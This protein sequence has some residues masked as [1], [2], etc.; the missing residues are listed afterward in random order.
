[1]RC[2]CTSVTK[3]RSAQSPGFNGNAKAISDRAWKTKPRR[4]AVVLYMQM[5]DDDSVPYFDRLLSGR[6]HIAANGIRHAGIGCDSK[7]KPAGVFRTTVRVNPDSVVNIDRAGQHGP[8]V[9]RKVYLFDGG[10]FHSTD[11]VYA[12][13][14][15]CGRLYV[16]ELK[17][18]QKTAVRSDFIR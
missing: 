2:N 9:F 8:S 5:M 1:M 17:K 6:R 4:K 11:A 3:M 12:T 13:T 18:Q 14:R 16:I 7:T 10:R 15:S